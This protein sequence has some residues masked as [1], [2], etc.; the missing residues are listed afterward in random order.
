MGGAL[1]TRRSRGDVGVTKPTLITTGIASMDHAT[2]AA[3][4]AATPFAA[5]LLP[6]AVRLLPVLSRIAA[7]I[8]DFR[9]AEPTPS[10]CHT[11]ETRLQEAL[12]ELGA[13]GMDPQEP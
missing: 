7:L 5:S 2:L 1:K 11:F 13:S 6:L 12:R 4:L 10:A 8:V 9:A 3:A